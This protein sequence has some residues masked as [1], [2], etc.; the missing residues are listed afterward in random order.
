MKLQHTHKLILLLIFLV[1]TSTN[2]LAADDPSIKGDLR[3]NIQQSMNQYI[4]NQTINGAMY[5]FDAVKGDLLKLQLKEL[6]SGIVKKGDFYVSC[7]DFVDQ[8]GRKIDIDFLVRTSDNAFVTT[9]AFVH[10]VDGKKRKYH[11]EKI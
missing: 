7:A 9:Q 2:A 1:V 3:T 11:L 10:S 6:H 5:V 8:K 4:Q